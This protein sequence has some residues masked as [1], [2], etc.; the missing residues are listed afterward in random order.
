M[1]YYL[2]NA[3]TNEYIQECDEQDFALFKKL[4][5]DHRTEFDIGCDAYGNEFKFM[6]LYV[7]I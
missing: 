6:S 3:K 5:P 7:N 4:Y 1:K 2:F